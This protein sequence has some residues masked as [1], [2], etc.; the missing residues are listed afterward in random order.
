[1]LGE[2]KLLSRNAATWDTEAVRLGAAGSRGL[3]YLEIMGLS[4]LWMGK[5]GL[6]FVGLRTV[7]WLGAA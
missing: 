2:S 1:M 6:G 7:L 4:A 3:R 5:L